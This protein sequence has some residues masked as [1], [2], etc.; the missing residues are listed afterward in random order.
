MEIVRRSRKKGDDE[1]GKEQ[2]ERKER[3]GNILERRKRVEIL[4]SAERR[5]GESNPGHN[6]RD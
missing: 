2:K 1:R 4:D 5:T 3:G 6:E